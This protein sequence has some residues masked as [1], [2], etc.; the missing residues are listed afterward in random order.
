MTGLP[1]PWSQKGTWDHISAKR[2]FV[3]HNKPMLCAD[4]KLPG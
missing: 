3:V 1:E 4:A 2:G